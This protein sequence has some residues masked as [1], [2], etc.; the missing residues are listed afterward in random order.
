LHYRASAII[1]GVLF[2]PLFQASAIAQD[3]SQED[4]IRVRTDLVAV[5]VVVSDSHGNRVFG[6]KAEDFALRDDGRL[7]KP[8]H[9]STGTDRVALAFLLDASGSA[10]EY[11]ARQREA[12]LALFSRFGPGSEVAILPF[13]E[14]ARVAVPFTTEIAKARSAFD[15]HTGTNHHTA[16]FDSAATA[17]QLFNQRKSDPTERRIIILTSDGLDTAS[18]MRAADVIN[19]ARADAISFYVIHFPLFVP[20]EGRLV[21]RQPAKGFRDL[22]QKTGGR[23]FSVGDAKSALDPHAQYDLS[24][25][26]KAIE[27]DLA[28]QYLLGFYPGGTT[29]DRVH[30][31][32]V[33]L[34]R[35]NRRLRVKT[36]RAEYSLKQKS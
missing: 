15:F 31:I 10:Q 25:V 9:F 32:D 18:A 4:I 7:V 21:A 20:S 17:I 29:V 28:S 3:P 22:A 33:Q 23:Y 24:A 35:N 6:L 19:R 5:P 30:R 1:F 11:L 8:E 16:I 14:K 36:L 26:F 13:S 2:V 12:A 34:T 27:D